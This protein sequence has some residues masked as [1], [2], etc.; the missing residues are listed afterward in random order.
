MENE[1]KSHFVT[2]KEF[3]KTI[4]VSTRTFYRMID[5]GEMPR[6]MKLRSKSVYYRSEM[7][8]YISQLCKTRT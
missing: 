1:T 5:E 3:A 6:P 8:D 7:D 2:L 4:G